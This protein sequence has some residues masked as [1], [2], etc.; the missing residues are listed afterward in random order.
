MQAAADAGKSGMVSVIGLSSGKVTPDWESSCKPC[1]S[2]SDTCF[3]LIS[4]L[5]H[6][7]AIPMGRLVMC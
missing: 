1:C 2:P 6:T 4:A 5:L 7:A 3:V